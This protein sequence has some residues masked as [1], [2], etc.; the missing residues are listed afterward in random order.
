MSFFAG[1]AQAVQEWDDQNYRT[2]EREAEQGF[3]I[4][5]REATERFSR[6]LQED[7]RQF[8]L[9]LAERGEEH[10]LNLFNLQRE[11]NRFSSGLQTLQTRVDDA[12]KL[13]GV[14]SERIAEGVALL[15]DE[16]VASVLEGSGQLE[17]LVEVIRKAQENG[18]LDPSFVPSILATVR[19]VYGDKI[20]IEDIAVGIRNALSEPYNFVGPEGEELLLSQVLAMSSEDLSKVSLSRS[21][22]VP[23]VGPITLP[24]QTA[25]P[26]SPEE[27]N[28]VKRQLT[29]EFTLLNTLSVAPDGSDKS[30]IKVQGADPEETI[31]E[32]I[33]LNAS[34]VKAREL[35]G[36]M[37]LQE[38]IALVSYNVNTAMADGVPTDEVIDMVNNMSESYLYKRKE[39]P[40][41]PPPPP[42]ADPAD[43]PPGTS[44]D[45][46]KTGKSDSPLDVEGRIKNWTSNAG[47]REK[48]L[49]INPIYFDEVGSFL[50]QDDLTEEDVLDY[51][52][53]FED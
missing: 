44:L 33:L 27:V 47:V 13:A 2:K 11:E 16:D 40:P 50:L 51:L 48:L 24:N 38:A 26:W 53:Q 28:S 17:G 7:D 41:P 21:T 35:M 30:Y 18:N 31:R 3:K 29:Q 49:S 6:E 14:R 34:T 45:L 37:T 32:T 39:V 52:N 1:V 25:K 42:P 4:K 19:G 8:R 43:L 10:D 5:E 15:G 12:R 36:T 22:P 20:S 9:S 46:L 23:T